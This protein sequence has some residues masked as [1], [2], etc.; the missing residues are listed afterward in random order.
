MKR[1]QFMMLLGGAFTAWPFATRAQEPNRVS[2]IDQLMQYA[3]WT[4]SPS[5]RPLGPHKT[6]SFPLSVSANGRYLITATEAPFL[7]VADSCQGGAIESVAD[8]R[9]Y[10]RQ[11]AAQGFNTIQFN[12][13]VT[14]YV[15]NPDA[16]NYTTRDGIPPFTGAKV[17][18]PNPTYFARMVQFV[19]IM[20]QN[21]LA[22]WLNPYE[23]GVGG[24]GQTDLNNAGADA[25]NTYGQ[26]IANLFVAYSNVMWHFG[27]DFE[28]SDK[29]GTANDASVQAL[30]N[31]I[32]SVA[33]NQLR[34]GELCFA[35]GTEGVSTFDDANF[36]PPLQNINGAYTYAPVYAAALRAYNDS[37]VD[38]GGFGAGTNTS[39]PC[40]TIM[41][42]SDYEWENIHGDPGIPV[43]M[44]RILWW[45]YL[46][47]A[48]GYIYGMHFTATAFMVSGGAP[49]SGYN[50]TIPLW[51]SNLNSPGV[52]ALGEFINLFN[53]IQW[54][55]LVPDQNHTVGTA[56]Y[57]TPAATGT[58]Q[59][60]NYV[61]VSATPDR[62]L[63]LAYF[64]QGR[65]STLTIA[66]SNFRA[67]V[68]ARW[69]DP[70][71]GSYA[72]IGT[73]LNGG[74][75]SFSPPG[76]NAGGDPDWVLVLAA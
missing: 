26:Y 74:T 8:F 46:S 16:T 43:N 39:P 17:T 70:T 64:P 44:R 52:I 66:M 41:V 33:P 47:G 62:S 68:T 5:S 28:S 22:A 31:G 67:S 32:K 12:L 63:A 76:N 3:E 71:N 61:T 53:T 55:N 20:Q 59:S 51:K 72:N 45:A 4:P 35:I 65:S 10:C 75:H 36:R 27:N 21:G 29:K 73:F 30:I 18:T 60:N 58:Y 13:I 56:G 1:R 34:G 49:V 14:G 69:L 11:R 19:Q 40:P 25:C 42:E 23:T 48:S 9:Y 6:N 57:G 38:F 54:W 24:T 2:R 15:G 7:M 50:N 37:S